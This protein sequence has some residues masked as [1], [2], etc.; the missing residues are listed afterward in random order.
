MVGKK[1]PNP[2]KARS[3]A[4]RIESLARYIEAPHTKSVREKCLHFGARGFLTDD[5][6]SQIAEMIALA[7]EGRRSRDPIV[8]YVLSWPEAERPSDEQVEEG[9]DLLLAEMDVSD[10]QVMYA[11]HGDTDNRHVHVMLNRVDPDTCRVVKINA[12]FDRRALYRACARIEHAQGWQ[13]ERHAPFRVND[14]GDVEDIGRTPA[15]YAPRPK[16]RQIDAERRTGER[17]AARQAIETAG[18]LIE[19]A[20]TWPELHQA[21][22]KHDVRYMRRGSGAVIA[23]G[24]VFVKAST[25]S[26]QATLAR[27]E[28][29]LGPYEVC[30]QAGGP[31]AAQPRAPLPAHQARR[32]ESAAG[33]VAHPSEARPLIEAAKSWQGLHRA[34]A[35]QRLRYVRKGSGAVIVAGEQGA[36]AMKASAVAR[37]AALRALEARLGP[38]EAPGAEEGPREEEMPHWADYAAERARH[39]EARYAAWVAREAEREEEERALAQRQREERE[40]LFRKRSWDG[41]LRALYLQRSLLAAEHAK[42]QA[43]LE[44][45]RRRARAA[46]MAEHP[47]WSDYPTWVRDRALAFLWRDRAREHPALEPESSPDEAPTARGAYDI[48]DYQGREVGDWL[49]YATR[50]QHARGE[51]AFVDRGRRITLHAR[52]DIEA[53]S[54]AAL[55][56]AAAKWGRMRARGSLAHRERSARLAAEL[57]ITL[58]NPELQ[59]LIEAHRREIAERREQ[60]VYGPEAVRLAREIRRI[61]GAHGKTRLLFDPPL[62]AGDLS[63]P[64][65]VS[66]DGAR[67][68]LGR[69]DLGTVALAKACTRGQ[70]PRPTLASRHEAHTARRARTTV[71]APQAVP[72]VVSPTPVL[73]RRPR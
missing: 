72:P 8:H 16:Q 28:K 20:G 19:A 31:E 36:V 3:K 24:E 26:R 41:L 64:R 1:V 27:L 63:A 39:Y 7:G 54:R 51:V 29:Q 40:K 12:G 10:H 18:P 65:H 58:T 61:A 14:A 21:L 46:C 33:R 52:D 57:G 55:Q 70:A 9:V 73:R 4:E 67:H 17:S 6:D 66:V 32:T 71:T 42:E 60:E 69:H 48:R 25:V 53:A 34:L 37:S 11:L 56:L 5:L 68:D 44:E 22:S 13:P 2:D 43:A 35:E 38:Y 62:A 49:I 15:Q 50:E 45:K 23:M 59:E 30:A 47:P